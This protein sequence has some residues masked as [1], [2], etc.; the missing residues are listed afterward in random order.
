VYHLPF[1]DLNFVAMVLSDDAIVVLMRA[2][3][4]LLDGSVEN[5]RKEFGR[6]THM[7]QQKRRFLA[8][9]YRVPFGRPR[10]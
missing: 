1:T 10:R 8:S 7:S 4:L 2:E 6:G 5:R 3:V 9:E